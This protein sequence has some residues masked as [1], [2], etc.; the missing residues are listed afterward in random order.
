MLNYH[1]LRIFHLVAREGGLRQAAARLHVT[2]PTIS[3]QLRQLAEAL[4]EPLF[5]KAGRRL[6]LTAA[7]RMALEYADE[8]FSLGSQLE[9]A[10]VR[11][12]SAGQKRIHIGIVNSLPKLLA[13]EL[14]RPAIS[15]PDAVWL[16]CHEA[17]VDDLVSLLAVN[18]FDLV[19]ADEPVAGEQHP[20]IF[21]QRLGNC[22][23]AVC[24]T[25]A[26]ARKYRRDFPRSLQDAPFFLPSAGMP[27]RRSI[28]AWFLKHRIAPRI[29]A[30]FDDTALMKDFAADGAG[31]V[32]LLSVALEAARRIYGW[33]I[34]GSMTGL[35]AEYYALYTARSSQ[36]P[37]IRKILER[38]ALKPG[39][40]AK[41]GKS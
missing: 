38:P 30:E 41:K 24:G 16:I 9:A 10:F 12:I 5:F 6:V 21:N 32:P 11:G 34:A 17:P 25:P 23:V 33:E 18:R 3:A 2:L 14:L 1:H 8:I 37:I 20:S 22:T 27:L 28:D 35:R 40:P 7:G 31:F 19:L 15:G 13:H 36:N 39:S 4:G 29:V 26:L